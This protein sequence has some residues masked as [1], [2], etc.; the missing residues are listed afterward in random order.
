MEF[1]RT[2]YFR[3][4]RSLAQNLFSLGLIPYSNLIMQSLTCDYHAFT[5]NLCLA[6]T[7]NTEWSRQTEQDHVLFEIEGDN[8]VQCTE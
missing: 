7:G 6:M 5:C 1:L 3:N 8:G 4:F 2:T